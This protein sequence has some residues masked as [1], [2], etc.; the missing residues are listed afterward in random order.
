VVD[1]VFSFDDA[2][3]AFRYHASGAFVG[4]VVIAV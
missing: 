1:R 2:V 4:K 3:P